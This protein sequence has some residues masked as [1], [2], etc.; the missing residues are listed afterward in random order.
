MEI[1]SIQI[2]K[3][4]F[5]GPVRAIVSV[6]ID[7]IFVI[8]DIKII[9]TDRL[10]VG[11][12]SRV[13]EHGVH[14]DVVHPINSEARQKI[15]NQIIT[16]YIKIITDNYHDMACNPSN[17]ETPLTVTPETNNKPAEKSKPKVSGILGV[18]NNMFKVSDTIPEGYII[19]DIGEKMPTGYLPVGKP[20]GEILSDGTREL[21]KDTLV[22][23]P[24]SEAQLILGLVGDGLTTIGKMSA[25][26]NR[27][28]YR[29]K[30]RDVKLRVL[31]CEIA[32]HALLKIPGADTLKE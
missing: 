16:A 13:D 17:D 26:L 2:R 24:T 20:T 14:R 3:Q 22:A 15:E 29:A 12:P 25:Y 19:W 30:S 31:H 27:Y 28:K 4:F 32:I 11:M 7:D 21:E 10:F 5:T 23:I 18:K 9:K 1:T 8:N 6:V